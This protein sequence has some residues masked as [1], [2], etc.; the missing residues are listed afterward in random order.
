MKQQLSHSP[1]SSSF[2]VS[3]GPVS[4]LAAT[5]HRKRKINVSLSLSPFLFTHSVHA[6]Y[7]CVY[8]PP[9][10]P[11]PPPPSLSLSLSLTLVHHS[12]KMDD[13]FVTSSAVCTAAFNFLRA[14]NF[15]M[16]VIVSCLCTIEATRSRFCKAQREIITL[17]TL[18]KTSQH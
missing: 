18:E 3:M 8:L 14:L 12:L 4:F 15:F 2:N 7:T 17:T 1:G 6:L 5:K 13:F 16:T 9:P 11:P 10:P